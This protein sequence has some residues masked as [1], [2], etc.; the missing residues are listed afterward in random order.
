MIYFIKKTILISSLFFIFSNASYAEWIKYLST[1][2]GDDFYIN[3]KSIET[4]GKF[5]FYESLSNYTK[6]PLKSGTRSFISTIKVDCE[7]LRFKFVKTKSFNKLWGKEL[8]K[9]NNKEDNEWSNLQPNDAREIAL[10][11]VCNKFD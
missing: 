1:E 6:K 4:K 9:I 3:A 10:R 8:K 7:L 5:V 11:A 2:I